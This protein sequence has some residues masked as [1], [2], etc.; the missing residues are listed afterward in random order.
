[1]DDITRNDDGSVTVRL[2]P[3][4]EGER[5]VT[6]PEPNMEEWA[7]M[8]ARVTQ[9]DEA[10]EVKVPARPTPDAEGK[11]S[12]GDAVRYATEVEQARIGRRRQFYAEDGPYALAFIDVVKMLTG[13]E[14]TMAD[15]TVRLATPNAMAL[16]L[17]TLEAPLGGRVGRT[18][19]ERLNDDEEEVPTPEV[20]EVPAPAADE[21]PVPPAS[22]DTDVSSP[23]GGEPSGPQPTPEPST[24]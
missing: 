6:L 3:R 4:G 11:I 23:P 2:H 22:P 8:R 5:F 18:L 16:I 21:P 19:S 15:L 17:D 12:D 10:M 24:P 13:R 9:A 20:V 14:L 7:R 1:M